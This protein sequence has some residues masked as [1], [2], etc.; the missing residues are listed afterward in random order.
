MHIDSGL[1]QQELG[2][3][4]R[5]LRRRRGWTRKQ[6]NSA[7]QADISLQTLATYEL[8]TRQCSVVR[9]AEICAALDEQPHL[10]LQRVDQRIFAAASGDVQVDLRR[11]AS[12]PQPELQPLRRW[13][14]SQMGL[15][16]TAA[17]GVV[18]LNL[19]AVERMAE[20]CGVETHDLLTRLSQLSPASSPNGQ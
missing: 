6:L 8:G 10:V 9:L 20:L 2:K 11:V 3:E 12:T 5:Q 4:L 14:A 19:S 1:Y 16:S 17:T 18:S 7:M 15:D 13:A